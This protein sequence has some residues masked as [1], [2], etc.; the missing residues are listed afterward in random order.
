MK[1]MMTSLSCLYLLSG[2]LPSDLL[3]LP[4]IMERLDVQN[5]EHVNNLERFLLWAK[6]FPSVI[7][8]HRK[9]WKER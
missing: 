3:G 2:V 6:Y 8:R 7:H 1:M 9:K 5:A 4:L